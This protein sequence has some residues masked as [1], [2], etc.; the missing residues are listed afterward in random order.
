MEHRLVLRSTK[1][2]REMGTDLE[3]VGVC[4]PSIGPTLTTAHSAPGV[5]QAGGERVRGW[6][7]GDKMPHHS[8]LGP[9]LLYVME[10]GSWAGVPVVR[11]TPGSGQVLTAAGPREAA[12]NKRLQP[13]EPRRDPLVVREGFLHTHTGVSP[14]AVALA[15]PSWIADLAPHFSRNPPKPWAS[16]HMG[17]PWHTVVMWRMEHGWELP[18]KFSEFEIL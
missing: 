9:G 6:G 7:P 13:L 3:Q 17:H 5:P 15:H 8:L 12:P 2:N 4:E 11:S 1:V 16:A 14:E 10:L 18:L